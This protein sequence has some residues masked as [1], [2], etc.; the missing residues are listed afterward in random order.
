ME[1]P[2]KII[3][4]IGEEP[5]SPLNRLKKN[6]GSILA[7]PCSGTIPEWIR[8]TSHLHYQQGNLLALK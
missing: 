7:D 2:K 8:S 6:L 1:N 4:K 3:L 5:F